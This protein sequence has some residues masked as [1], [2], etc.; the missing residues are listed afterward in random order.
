MARKPIPPAPALESL[1]PML[2]TELRAVP[3]T[4]D[5]SWELKMDG[6]RLLATT[7]PE[8]RLQTKGGADASKWFP[9][10]V[11]SLAALPAGGIVDGEACVLDEIGRSDFD[12]LHARALRRRWTPGDDPVI[13]CVFDALA[14]GG[15]D[16]RG[17]PI[18][19]RKAALHKILRHSIGG[20]LEMS[21]VDDGAWLYEQALALKLE[22]VVGKRS[23]SLYQAG[24]RSR[25]WVKVKR[26]GAVPPGRFRRSLG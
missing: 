15:R 10:I 9:E 6:Y 24:V 3:T 19:K 17:E 1:S 8:A 5:W 18:E 14:A 2:L 25:D 12:R 26:P 21:S 20:L 22:G 7:G 16:L 11:A 13:F 23:G 4:G